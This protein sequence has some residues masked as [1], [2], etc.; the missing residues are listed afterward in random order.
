MFDCNCLSLHACYIYKD[1]FYTETQF[2]PE[3]VLAEEEGTVPSLG[4]VCVFVSGSL[5]NIEDLIQNR[6]SNSDSF[7]HAF[8]CN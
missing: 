1:P 5:F 8:K 3:S 4:S 2:E 6:M 7:S